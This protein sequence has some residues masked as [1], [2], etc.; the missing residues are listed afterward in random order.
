MQDDVNRVVEEQAAVIESLKKD[1]SGLESSL[2]SLTTDHE[3]VVKENQLL[4][5]A[6]T[7]Q[8]E[9]QTQADNA[10][11]AAEKNRAEADE[12]IQKLEQVILSLRY[13]LQAQ[14]PSIGNDFMPMPPQPPDVF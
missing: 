13:Y 7:I 6:V 1:K 4:R 5:K 11:K 2:A 9:R 12:Q 3:R 14:E 8:Q 10:L